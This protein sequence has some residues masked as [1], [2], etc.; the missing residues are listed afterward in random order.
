MYWQLQLF[1]L[2]AAVAAILTVGYFLDLMMKTDSKD[3]LGKFLRKTVDKTP[4]SWLQL[5]SGK[6]SEAFDKIYGGSSSNLELVIWLGLVLSPLTLALTRIPFVSGASKPEDL[7]IIAMLGAFGYVLIGYVTLVVGN[8]GAMI[9]IAL[10]GRYVNAIGTLPSSSSGY[11]SQSFSVSFS[12]GFM[13]AP[14][15]AS[16]ASSPVSYLVALPA[17]LSSPSPSK[18]GEYRFTL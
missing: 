5:A 3:C 7:L 6:F 14:S 10:W 1:A 11:L 16:S 4:E 15:V 9:G 13:G 12:V 18:R 17:V 8:A 2:F